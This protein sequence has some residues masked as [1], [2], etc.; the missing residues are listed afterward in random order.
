MKPH[1]DFPR[2]QKIAAYKPLL[3][4]LVDAAE[5]EAKAKKERSITISRSN[6]KNN[7][8]YQSPRTGIIC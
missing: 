1:P 4:D 6:Q 7:R 3:T 8:Q 5:A 2:Q